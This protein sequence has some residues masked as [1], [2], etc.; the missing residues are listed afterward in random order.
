LHSV[1]P[2]RASNVL[3]GLFAQI[4]EGEVETPGY[5]LLNTSGHANAS[6]LGKT[7]QP[8]RDIH[9]VTE[10]VV[11]LDNNV[12]L[13]NADTEFDAIVA[14]C[15]GISRIHPVLPLG[16][17]TQCINH[18]G[19]FDQQA[20]TGRFNDAAPMFGDLRVYN[21]RPDRP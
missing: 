19:K 12:A 15:T 18:T 11:L 9:P 16:R 8:S 7:L 4:V 17:T 10:D 3:E 20:I 2:H 5:V 13:V 6:W 14:R 1:D 21:L